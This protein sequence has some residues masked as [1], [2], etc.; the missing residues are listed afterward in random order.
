MGDECWA[1][2]LRDQTYFEPRRLGIVT[3]VGRAGFTVRLDVADW[4][5]RRT[6]RVGFTQTK[7]YRT[8]AEAEAYCAENPT[9]YTGRVDR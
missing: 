8:R 4:K 5:R 6:A 9:L 1:I 2:F 3:G 7:H